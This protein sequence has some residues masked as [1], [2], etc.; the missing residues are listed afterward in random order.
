M[1]P[2][3]KIIHQKNIEEHIPEYFVN[4]NKDTILYHNYDDTRELQVIGEKRV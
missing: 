2:K 1:W 4:D 3:Q